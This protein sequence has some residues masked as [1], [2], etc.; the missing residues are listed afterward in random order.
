MARKRKAASSSLN[1]NTKRSKISATQ[2]QGIGDS[3]EDAYVNPKDKHSQQPQAIASGSKNV[4]Q[5]DDV[6]EVDLELQEILAQIKAQEES[7]RLA[8]QLQEEYDKFDT[9]HTA[10][11]SEIEISSVIHVPPSKEAASTSNG[12]ATHRV[13]RQDDN[14]L[15]RPDQSLEPF[16]GLFT[17]SRKCTNCGK[18]VKSPRGYVCSGSPF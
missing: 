14:V 17:G 15:V 10:L 3:D 1:T 8:K 13:T 16:R 12:A 18:Q 11:D 2:L 5:L 4:L 6:N 9:T 7:E